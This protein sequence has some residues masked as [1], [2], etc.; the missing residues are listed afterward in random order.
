M[1]TIIEPFRIHSIEPLVMT[2]EEERRA[3]LAE[4]RHNLGTALLVASAGIFVLFLAGISW[5]LI[6]ALM[7]AGAAAAPVDAPAEPHPTP[8]P[9]TGPGTEGG[10]KPP[11]GEVLEAARPAMRGLSTSIQ[12]EL[13][14]FIGP[15]ANG[16]AES[17]LEVAEA[18]L[19]APF[20]AYRAR[21][22]QA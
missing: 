20:A 12:L 7:V 14:G 4:A 9:A 15:L 6:G 22:L 17:A 2:S 21:F 19:V 16:S 1:K 13:R 10:E 3:A 8:D 5:R 18:D 11:A